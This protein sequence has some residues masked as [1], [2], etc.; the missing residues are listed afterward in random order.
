[1]PPIENAISNVADVSNCK[2]DVS[3]GDLDY[4]KCT[5]ENKSSNTLQPNAVSLST[6]GLRLHTQLLVGSIKIPSN[7]KGLVTLEIYSKGV[8]KIV[9]EKGD[10]Y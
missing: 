5:F 7:T 9:I 4:Y 2:Y 1:M 8:D 3:L 10:V 6:D